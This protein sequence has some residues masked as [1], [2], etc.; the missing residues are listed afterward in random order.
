MKAKRTKQEITLNRQLLA[1]L[2]R[3]FGQLLEGL[4]EVLAIGILVDLLALAGRLGGHHDHTSRALGGGRGTELGAGSDEN[5]GD[6]VVLAQNGD[7]GD[8]VHGRDVGSEND[9]SR[10][11][12]DGSVGG[13][14]G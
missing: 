8:D 5:V 13:R 6:A 2:L 1:F 10:G 12:I 4:A 7:V 14:D 3:K 11:S 9:N